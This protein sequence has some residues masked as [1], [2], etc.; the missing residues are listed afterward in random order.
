MIHLLFLI[1]LLL[2]LVA[3]YISQNAD[4]E[5]A[6]L[7]TTI[8]VVSLFASIIIAPWQIQLLILLIV[9][10]GA[11]QLWQRNEN[12]FNLEISEPEQTQQSPLENN[13]QRKYRG[14]SYQKTTSEEQSVDNTVARKYRGI[15]WTKHNVPANP[16]AKPKSELKYRGN[17]VT[18]QPDSSKS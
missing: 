9:M 14:V 11:K 5:I 10:L 3:G 4:T 1:P 18:T 2:G 16:P 6:Y 7:T 12:K 8:S 13:N 17:R 15:S